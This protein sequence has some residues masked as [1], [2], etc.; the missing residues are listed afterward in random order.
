MLWI[1]Y[2]WLFTNS[3]AKWTQIGQ[4][5]EVRQKSEQQSEPFSKEWQ[6]EK[7]LP[8][9]L[10]IAWQRE[11]AGRPVKPWRN[12]EWLLHSTRCAA[13]F[14]LQRLRLGRSEQRQEE[15]RQGEKEEEEVVGWSLEN[16]IKPSLWAKLEPSYVNM[17]TNNWRPSKVDAWGPV[18]LEWHTNKTDT[19]YVCYVW[20]TPQRAWRSDK[21]RGTEIR[22]I[23]IEWTD[24]S[25]CRWDGIVWLNPPRQ[26][27]CENGVQSTSGLHE[28][29]LPGGP[30]L[31][32]TKSRTAGGM[33]EVKAWWR[34]EKK[35]ARKYS[36]QLEQL[37]NW[38][39]VVSPYH[40]RAVHGRS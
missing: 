17:A 36:N 32:W 10:R 22:L 34:S 18:R 20:E 6:E 29:D 27:E 35:P 33:R 14:E 4:S 28:V 38:L 30:H 8:L 26:I 7:R 37:G 11:E 19:R 5:K 25:Q 24:A 15:E 3:T 9:S 40:W 13:V 39:L 1:E 23:L 21:E 16:S 31:D 12:G 2:H